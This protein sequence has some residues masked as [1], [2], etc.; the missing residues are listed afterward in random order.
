M[1]MA[2]EFVKQCY[3]K[4]QVEWCQILDPKTLLVFEEAVA[5]SIF[6]YEKESR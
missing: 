5:H 3:K 6:R 2:W 4:K 1:R